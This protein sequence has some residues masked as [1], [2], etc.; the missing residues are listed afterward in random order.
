MFDAESIPQDIREKAKDIARKVIFESSGDLSPSEL[1][2][3]AN[4]ITVA[5]MEERTKRQKCNCYF[6]SDCDGSC[7][8]NY[9]A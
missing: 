1:A 9:G 4:T 3:A 2:I 8:P 6:P 7:D 5:L